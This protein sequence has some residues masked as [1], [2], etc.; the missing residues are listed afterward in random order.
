MN[1]TL[2][3]DYSIIV[4]Q[5]YDNNIH[6]EVKI[7]GAV[8]SVR[9][10]DSEREMLD[11]ASALYGCGVSSLMKRLAFEK[12]EDEYDLQVIADYEKAKA[13]G[14]LKTRPIEE[15]WKELDL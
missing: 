3:A 2:R 7:M 12:L 11:K 9:V 6:Q 10:S 13:D 15:L 4:I 1:L 8:I 14:T 5:M